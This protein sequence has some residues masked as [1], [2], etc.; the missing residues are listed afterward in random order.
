MVAA[1]VIGLGTT[2]FAAVFGSGFVQF[3]IQRKDK[4]E[5]RIGEMEKNIN[6][7]MDALEKKIDKG[8]DEREKTGKERFDI[9]E[10]K[11]DELKEFMI[12][13]AKNDEERDK[14]IKCVGSGVMMLIHSDLLDQGKKFVERGAITHKEKADLKALFIPYEGLGGNG[15]GKE[16]YDQCMKLDT[17]FEEEAIKMDEAINKKKRRR[18]DD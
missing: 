17:V 18:A 14:Y 1:T 11:Y 8:L 13:H 2:A 4:K 9:H 3:M 6:V 7:R 5:D 16:I 10:E 12:Q 15:D